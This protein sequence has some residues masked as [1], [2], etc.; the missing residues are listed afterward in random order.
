MKLAGKFHSALT[1]MGYLKTPMKRPKG[2]V[3]C[4]PKMKGLVDSENIEL[5]E[6][7][8]T[9]ED[10]CT[11]VESS[12]TGQSVK[13]VTRPPST[14]VAHKVR[15]ARYSEVIEVENYDDPGLWWQ[16]DE[17]DDITLECLSLVEANRSGPNCINSCTLRFLDQGW[18]NS[19][20]EG[21][22][23]LHKMKM[24]PQCRGLE[25][26]ILLKFDKMMSDHVRNVIDIQ[27]TA[28]SEYLVRIASR[29]TSQRWEELALVRALFD[30]E[31]WQTKPKLTKRKSKSRLQTNTQSRK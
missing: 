16:D 1:N 6:T 15:F 29:Q 14:P 21:S 11:S 18:R 17:C 30:T 10:S 13:Q 27:H 22:E 5:D 8:T 31:A 4:P 24:E 7:V 12:C 3:K 25:R 26:H 2:S 28:K 23:L 9:E 19:C 20:E